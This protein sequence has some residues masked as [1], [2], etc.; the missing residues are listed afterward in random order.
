LKVRNV[1][2]DWFFEIKWDEN[3]KK[4]PSK[5]RSAGVTSLAKR[6]L[7]DDRGANGNALQMLASVS[8][9]VSVQFDVKQSLRRS[10]ITQKKHAT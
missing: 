10:P 6:L 5:S 3:Y 1:Y 2:A 8:E 7:A 9:S 4:R